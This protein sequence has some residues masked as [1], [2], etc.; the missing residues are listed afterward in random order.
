MSDLRD[1]QGKLALVTGAGDGIGEMLARQLADSGL[2]V[3]VQDIRADAAARV[4]ADIGEIAFPIAFDVSDREA[5]FQAADALRSRGPLNL[6]WINAGVGVGSPILTGKPKTIEWA[7]GVNLYGVIWTAQAFPPLMAAAT[8]P[9]HVGFTASTAAL[10]APQGQFPLY[11]TS[12][13]A[14]FAFAEALSAELK[15]KD[16]ASTILCPGLL[17]TK[18]WDGARARPERYGGAKHMDPSISKPWDEAKSPD[19]MW[20]E[21]AR[22]INDGGGYLACATDGDDTL[23]AH[24]T[25]TDAIRASIVQI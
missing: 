11:S 17:N 4:A 19:L 13:H 7:L 3:A 8:G 9:T 20:P 2:K 25:R 24:K 16:I 14:T 23:I 5:C 15:T 22:S 6:L 21:I 1:Y 12:K 18:I 10:R